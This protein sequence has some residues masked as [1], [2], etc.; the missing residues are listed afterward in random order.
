MTE[1]KS[2]LF[3]AIYDWILLNHINTGTPHLTSMQPCLLTLASSTEVWM[4][5]KWA[6][7]KKT[8]KKYLIS[9]ADIKKQS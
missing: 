4:K 8:N 7:K 2:Q 6:K 5:K 3:C 1:V 9:W